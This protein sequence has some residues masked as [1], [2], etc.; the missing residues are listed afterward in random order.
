MTEALRA[1]GSDPGFEAGISACVSAV[2]RLVHDGY[3]VEVLD[4]EGTVLVDRIDGG[5]MTE[6]VSYIV[7][8][9]AGNIVDEGTLQLASGDGMPLSFAPELGATTLNVGDGLA[10]AFIECQAPPTEEPTT[11]PAEHQL[12]LDTHCTEDNFARFLIVNV[13]ADM[14]EPIYYSVT[15]ES[16]NLVDEDYVQLASGELRVLEYAFAGVLTLTIEGQQITNSGC[17]PAA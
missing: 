8:D 16:G 11:P 12:T 2:A 15:D 9:T 17:Q 10:T 1:P 6:P 3:A 7:A 13:G 14:A 4:T 5:D